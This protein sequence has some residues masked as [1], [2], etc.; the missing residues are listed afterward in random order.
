MVVVKL[1]ASC[2]I[3]VFNNCNASLSESP[4]LFLHLF[5]YIRCM[6]NIFRFYIQSSLAFS[7]SKLFEL[8]INCLAILDLLILFLLL[9]LGSFLNLFILKQLG[10][11]FQVFPC[12]FS[13]LLLI[14]KPLIFRASFYFNILNLF[15]YDPSCVVEK[16]FDVFKT[17]ITNFPI[18]KSLMCLFIVKV[19]KHIFIG[20]FGNFESLSLLLPSIGFFLNVFLM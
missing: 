3:S 13:S 16:T 9:E 14:V 4:R 8:F 18:G 7:L 12:I 19:R 6:L 5:E 17:L 2:H 15:I 1:V 20:V 11:Q 10:L